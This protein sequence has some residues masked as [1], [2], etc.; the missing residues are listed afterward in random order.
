[1]VAFRIDFIRKGTKNN[2]RALIEN[3]VCSEWC[4]WSFVGLLQRQS[5]EKETLDNT[6]RALM[7]AACIRLGEGQYAA[8]AMVRSDEEARLAP[9]LLKYYIYIYLSRHTWCVRCHRQVA[10]HRIFRDGSVSNWPVETT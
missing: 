6:A 5:A 3:V 4:K 2:Q 1:M 10:Q 7:Y 9:V 8:A